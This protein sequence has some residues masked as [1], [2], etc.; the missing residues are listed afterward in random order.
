MLIE[1]ATLKSYT[2]EVAEHYPTSILSEDH[3]Y[4]RNPE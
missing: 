4:A 2:D 1:K 3:D